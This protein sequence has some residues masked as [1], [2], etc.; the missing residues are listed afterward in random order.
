MTVTLY[1]GDC[2]DILPTLEAGSV[3]AVVTDPPYGVGKAAWDTRFP[4]EWIAPAWR[5][6]PRMLVMTGPT[7]FLHAGNAL[8]RY[9]DCVAMHATNGMTKTRIAFGNWLPVLACG[10]WTWK[11]RKSILSYP[12][13]PT[14]RIDHPCPKPIRGMLKLIE[15]YTEPDWTILDPFMGSGTTGVACVQT[16]R[17]FIG[18]EIDEGYFNIAKERIEAAQREMVQKELAI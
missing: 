5:I 12:I 1:R 10:D 4:T 13:V 14:D 6:A 18:I 11:P 7:V 17:N 16:G 15:K 8:G 9:R 2:L 3:D